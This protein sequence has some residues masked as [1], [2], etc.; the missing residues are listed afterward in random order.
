MSFA[1]V[2]IYHGVKDHN[3]DGYDAGDPV[4]P[5]F[6]YVATMP[7]ASGAVAE[8]N[9]VHEAEHAYHMFNAPAEYLAGQDA[10]T[11]RQYRAL[12]LRSLSV[13]DLV[14]VGSQ[15]YA[16]R[17]VGFAKLAASTAALH[18]APSPYQDEVWARE[19]AYGGD[20]L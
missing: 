18:I 7:A 20:P 15:V 13:G 4:A 14:A 9:R 2:T 17:S 10:V 8:E 5:V 16:V 6:T 11:A 12:R 3:F 1:Q 19:V